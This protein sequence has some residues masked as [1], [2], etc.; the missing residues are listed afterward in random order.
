M[1]VTWGRSSNSTFEVSRT[2][3]DLGTLMSVLR[4]SGRTMS[5]TS[6]L[7]HAPQREG[8]GRVPAPVLGKD[9]EQM[10]V[11]D[12][13]AIAIRLDKPMFGLHADPQAFTPRSSASVWD[14]PRSTSPWIRI[15]MYC[16]TSRK[17]R[18][19]QWTSS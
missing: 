4:P 13:L 17:R 19:R 1:L 16:Q 5:E 14:M 18:L 10:E 7:E 15:V 12:E 6:A 9:V 11:M 8:R 3:L 2:P